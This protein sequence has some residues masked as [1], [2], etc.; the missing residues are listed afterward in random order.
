MLNNMK[1]PTLWILLLSTAGAVTAEQPRPRWEAG[2]GVA[3]FALADYRGSRE[4][5]A[6]V[7]P[8]PYAIYRSRLL[9]ADRDGVRG[10]LFNNPDVELNVSSTASL[11]TE[12]D[13]NPLREGMP[14]ID[15]TFELGPALDINLTGESVRQGWKLQLPIRT[16]YGFSDDGLD[17]V[18]WLAHPQLHYRS[19][20]LDGG[21]RM[22]W[23][24]GV[25][26]ANEAYHDYYYAV[27]PQ[28]ARPGRPAYDA[29]SGYS[30]F[31]SVAG[32][33][34]RHGRLWYGAY[35]RYDN[36]SGTVFEDSPLVETDDYYAVGVAMAW[37]LGESKEK[38]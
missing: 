5:S 17:H 11:A 31:S 16:V 27:D 35:L 33:T 22:H 24:G 18:G 20:P 36:L 38:Y 25:L 6:Q 32:F 7:L 10:I 37:I 2:V 29:E 34:R 15:P 3:T 4:R 14:E 28:H 30:G 12:A 19:R 23:T 21:W 9:K 13:D 26:Y 1:T 8:Y